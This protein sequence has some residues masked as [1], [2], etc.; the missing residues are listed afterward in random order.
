MLTLHSILRW[1]VL[2]VAVVAIARAFSGWFGRRDW[3]DMDERLG[4]FFTISL[5]V[6]LLIGLILYIFLSPFTQA[7]FQDFG[8]AMA[9]GVL[10]FWAVEHIFGM[11]VAVAVAHIGR[12]RAK[13]AA[14]PAA[15]HRRA[16]IFY[17][18]AL[19]AILLTI[20]WPFLAHGRPLFRLFGLAWL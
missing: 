10:R 6:Q 15:R 5:D 4:L 1:I 17:G 18:L 7:A 13:R 20:P 2:I 8:A 9:S 14:E 3:I 11:L 16:A 12:A 19:V